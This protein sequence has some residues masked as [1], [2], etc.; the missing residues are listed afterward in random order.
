MALEEP[1]APR[2]W[3]RPTKKPRRARSRTAPVAPPAAN[4]PQE[5]PNRSTPGWAPARPAALNP[6]TERAQLQPAL[7]RREAIPRS[8]QAARR[9]PA[10]VVAVAV[11]RLAEAA[12]PWARRAEAHPRTVPAALALRPSSALPAVEPAALLRAPEEAAAAS[13]VAA[14]VARPTSARRAGVRPEAL[15]KS[16]RPAAAVEAGPQRQERHPRSAQ[17]RRPG[18]AVRPA[19]PRARPRLPGQTSAARRQAGPSWVRLPGEPPRSGRQGSVRGRRRAVPR[20]S[21]FRRDE[22]PRL[23]AAATK[24]A[25]AARFFRACDAGV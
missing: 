1:P 22:T 6:T 7:T 16:A 21:R 18:W 23:S 11:G 4:W 2:S 12:A 25:R 19:A 17:V 24:G 5:I 8:A 9:R 3:V 15:P 10:V 13:R 14:A 20:W